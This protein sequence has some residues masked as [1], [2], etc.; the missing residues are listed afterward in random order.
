MNYAELAELLDGLP[1]GEDGVD[2]RLLAA[3]GLSGWSVRADLVQAV[4]LGRGLHPR[5]GTYLAAC[6]RLSGAG[7]WQVHV[8]SFRYRQ[9]ALVHLTAQGRARLA[10]CG[11]TAVLSEWERLE[12][13]HVVR[14]AT[15]AHH[16][17]AVCL[18]L[19]HA[20]MRGY[21]TN[22]CPEPAGYHRREPDALVTQDGVRYYVEVQRRGGERWRKRRKWRRLGELDGHAAICALTPAAAARLAQEA[23]IAGLAAG[24]L[25]DLATL[26][27]QSPPSLWTFCWRSVHGVLEPVTADD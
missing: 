16:T 25:T 4:N 8:A 24:Y 11:V 23:Q 2:L 7:L 3:L 10:D 22:A 20:R 21:E 12:A 17:A 19:H 15:S 14:G 26:A 9:V 18:L 27:T 13:T 1:W 5:S 6:R